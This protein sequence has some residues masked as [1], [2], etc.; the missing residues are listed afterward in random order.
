ML[1]ETYN[2]GRVG[3]Y[4]SGMFRIKY[5]LTQGDTLSPFLLN[6]GL[7]YVIRRVH[8]NQK[9]FKS[10][11]THQFLVYAEDF[12]VEGGGGGGE[13]YILYRKKQKL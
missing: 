7:V 6:F 1:N 9:G 8:V 10:N 13:A 2:T 3:K 4:L 12:N 11:G 5:G